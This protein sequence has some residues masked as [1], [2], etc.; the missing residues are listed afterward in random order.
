MKMEPQFC[1]TSIVSQA[2]PIDL[3]NCE[4]LLAGVALLL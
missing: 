3:F 2:K 4:E 1:F